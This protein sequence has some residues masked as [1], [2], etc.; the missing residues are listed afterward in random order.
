M[1]T[2]QAALLFLAL[3]GAAAPSMAGVI[4]DLLGGLFGGGNNGGGQ[5]TASVPEPASIALLLT[6]LAGVAIGNRRRK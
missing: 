6:G 1:K 4:G 3:S 2:V 5:P